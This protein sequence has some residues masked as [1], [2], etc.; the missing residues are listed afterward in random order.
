MIDK[1]KVAKARSQ[2]LVFACAMCTKLHEGHDNGLMGCSS[3]RDCGSPIDGFSF[4]DYDGPLKGY[5]SGF[6]YVCGEK[7]PEYALE[8]VGKETSMDVSSRVGCCKNCFEKVVQRHVKAREQER[9]ISFL[10]V[11][12]EGREVVA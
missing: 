1:D 2:G 4:D 7:N 6:C 10:K 5:L 12:S 3:T 9:K 8:P 11:D